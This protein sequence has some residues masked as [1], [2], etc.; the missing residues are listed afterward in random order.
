M[1]VR[2]LISSNNMIVDAAIEVRKDGGQLLDAYYIGNAMHKP[3]YPQKVPNRPE[4][5]GNSRMDDKFYRDAEY[6]PES[7]NAWE[8]GKDY[9]EVKVKRS[10]ERYLNLEVYE[11]GCITAYSGIGR[12]DRCGTFSGQKISIVALPNGYLYQ[13]PK[14]T[15]AP[16]QMMAGQMLLDGFLSGARLEEEDNG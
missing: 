15:A 1:T 4:Y 9:W 2:D 8:D 6:K 14:V 12:R 3:R 11:W 5:A 10:P 16:E 7:I 13:K